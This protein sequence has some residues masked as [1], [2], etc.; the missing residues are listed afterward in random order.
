MI[1][2]HC[3]F[4]RKMEKHPV[5]LL[6]RKG[7]TLPKYSSDSFIFTLHFGNVVSRFLSAYTCLIILFPA[8]VA[9][10]SLDYYYF[11]TGYVTGVQ[12]QLSVGKCIS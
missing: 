1:V 5:I 9:R 2:K 7:K 8:L 6:G 3:P 11:L 12:C 10:V 4:P